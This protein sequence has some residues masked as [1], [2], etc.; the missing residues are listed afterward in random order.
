MAKFGAKKKDEDKGD[1]VVDTKKKKFVAK[2]DKP[3]KVAKE[4]ANDEPK[5]RGRKSQYAGKKI[6]VLNKE[7]GARA[8]SKRAAWLDALVSSKTV[9]EAQEKVEGLTGNVLAFAADEGFV[10]FV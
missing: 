6:K 9:E 8:G 5:G 2:S 1:V 3:A 4:A 7:H 10:E